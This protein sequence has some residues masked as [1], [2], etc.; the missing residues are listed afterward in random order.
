MLGGTTMA[1]QRAGGT[2]VVRLSGKKGAATF[3]KILN[4]QPTRFNA[5]AKAKE[6]KKELRK[7]GFSL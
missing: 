3:Y 4:T 1:I 6:A 5:K 7:Q 2:A